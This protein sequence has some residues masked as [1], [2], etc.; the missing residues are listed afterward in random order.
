MIK[1]MTGYGR[2]KI[3]NSS[4]SV[5]VE[6]KSVNHKYLDLNINLPYEL[7][8]LDQEIRSI[9]KSYIYRGR[10][11]FRL[12]YKSAEE[13]DFLIRVNKDFAKEIYRSLELLNS[14]LKL[15]NEIEISDIISYKGVIS[16]EER[17]VQE[18]SIRDL[19]IEACYSSLQTLSS[20]RVE[21][22]IS[23][24]EDL[25]K[26][27]QAIEESL[28]FIEINRKKVKDSYKE[29]LIN[30]LVDLDIEED[31]LY[32]RIAME[33][34]LYGE[35]SDVNEE[36]VRLR[37]HIETFRKTFLEDGT[38]GRKLDIISQEM[39]REA[40]TMASK[41]ND[42]RLKEEVIEIKSFVDRL[43]E[44]VQNIE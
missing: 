31:K 6:I 21:E 12:A 14:D 3:E 7:G 1:S 23:L 30:S 5:S 19:V 35:K 29:K 4:Y 42:I 8:F 22:G 43:K 39:L 34:A 36:I 16:I 25:E 44:H 28:N 15:A 40:N 32:E 13:E 41:I 24:L 10:I 9:I 37:S 11:D 38:I 33:V 26:Q 2:A 20:A 17:E 27:L 18:T